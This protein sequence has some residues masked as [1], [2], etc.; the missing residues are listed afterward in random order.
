MGSTTV[1]VEIANPVR[2]SRTRRLTLPIDPGAVYSVIP[3][4]ILWQLG[5]RPIRREKFYLTDGTMMVRGKGPAFFKYGD[6]VGVA[7]VVFGVQ[8]DHVLLGALTLQSLGLI[9]DPLQRQLKALPMI[10]AAAGAPSS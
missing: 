9:L 8:S 6:R 1:E 7:D 2:R 5:M 10:L 4:T 3:G